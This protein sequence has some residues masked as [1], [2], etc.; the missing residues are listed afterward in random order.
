MTL[1][2]IMNMHSRNYCSTYL[3]VNLEIMYRL[4]ESQNL[5]EYSDSD[6]TSDKQKQK[7]VLDHVYILKR[8]SIL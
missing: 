5:I 8:E 7:S 2:N 4:S 6:Y 3:T 1:L